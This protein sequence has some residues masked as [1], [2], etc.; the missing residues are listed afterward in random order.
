M[1]CDDIERGEIA[2]QYLLGRLSQD[3]QEQFEAHYFDCPEC[4]ARLRALEDARAEL[5]RDA[6]VPVPAARHHARTFGAVLAAAAL[7][8]LAVRVSQESDPQTP[9]TGQPATPPAIERGTQPPATSATPVTPTSDENRLSQLGEFEPPPYRPSR[10]RAT[11]TAAQRAFRD[12]MDAYDRR[13][14]NAAVAGLRRAIALDDSLVPAHFFLGVCELETGRI[15]D[16]VTHLQ[17]VVALGESPYLEDAHFLLAKARIRQRDVPGA[18]GELTKVVALGG[19]RREE[20]ARLL[21][22]L[23]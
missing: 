20:A 21:A 13:E 2:E 19:E 15:P 12:A 10:L 6:A 8:V 22:Q 11:T 1:T 9:H 14:W 18:R 4:L 7:V 3:E 17:R 23:P 5:S 16:G